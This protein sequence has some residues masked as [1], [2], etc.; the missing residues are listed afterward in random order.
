MP[1]SVRARWVSAAGV[2]EVGRA[3]VGRPNRVRWCCTR[4]DREAGFGFRGVSVRRRAGTR[5]PVPRGRRPARSNRLGPQVPGPES[6]PK[7]NSAVRSSGVVVLKVG[8]QDPLEMTAVPDQHPVQALGSCCPHEPFRIS[9]R[10][11]RP[12]RDLEYLGAGGGEDGVERA[13][14][15]VSRSRIKKRNVLAA[16]SSSISRL[17]AAWVT[18]APVGWAVTPARRTRRRSNSMKNNT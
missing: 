11:R 6:A 16:P 14:N 10:P 2:C 9:V 15:L 5:G 1:E 18:H 7:Q 17:R 12:R 4:P 3:R 8:G 13:V